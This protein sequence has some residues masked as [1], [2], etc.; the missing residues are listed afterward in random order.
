MLKSK[1]Q[2]TLS[3]FV[4]YCEQ[5]PDERFW[6]AL[7]N[8]AKVPYIFIGNHLASEVSGGY[9]TFYISEKSK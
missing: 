2:K 4:T 3:S 6:Q 8:W 9:D 7:R 5:H 1:N